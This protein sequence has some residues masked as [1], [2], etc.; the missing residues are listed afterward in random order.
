MA[1]GIG[2]KLTSLDTA[3]MKPEESILVTTTGGKRYVITKVGGS[4]IPPHALSIGSGFTMTPSFLTDP[5][6]KVGEGFVYVIDT[7]SEGVDPHYAYPVE[8]ISWIK[9]LP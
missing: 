3:Q 2:P 6:I 8:E 1:T 5:V 7:G 4:G 9:R